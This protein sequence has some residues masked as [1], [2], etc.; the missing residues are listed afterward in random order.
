MKERVLP[1]PWVQ[2]PAPERVTPLPTRVIPTVPRFVTDPLTATTAGIV[3]VPLI[4]LPVPLKV[5][6]LALALLKS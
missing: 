2:A 4:V 5:H 1:A 6:V 3:N